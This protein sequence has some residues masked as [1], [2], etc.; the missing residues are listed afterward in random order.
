MFSYL[1]NIFAKEECVSESETESE[2]ES[3]EED[4]AIEIIELDEEK[5]LDEYNKMDYYKLIYLEILEHLPNKFS[6][7]SRFSNELRKQ[8]K[9]KNLSREL[10]SNNCLPYILQN[11]DYICKN[12][13]QGC[14]N[15]GLKNFIKYKY[16]T[17]DDVKI[18]HGIVFDLLQTYKL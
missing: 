11:V 3:C 18:L 12:H 14:S 17:M 2:I 16:T 13:R 1:Y 4:Y 15:P 6:T 10:Y 9:M 5:P 7:K 8:M